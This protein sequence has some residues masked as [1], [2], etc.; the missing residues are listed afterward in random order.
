MQMSG[1]VSRYFS[2]LISEFLRDPELN[3]D[4]VLLFR[5]T[6]NVHLADLDIAGVA[7]LPFAN[8]H[9][10]AAK[11]IR[12]QPSSTLREIGLS[13]LGGGSSVQSKCDVVHLTHFRPREKDVRAGAR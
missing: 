6:S 4:P 9:T 7:R 5:A 3:I 11:V 8:V 12:H 1:G 10:L 2:S 13:V